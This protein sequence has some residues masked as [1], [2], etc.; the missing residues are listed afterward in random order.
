MLGCVSQHA[1]A[2]PHQHLAQAEAKELEAMT[3]DA[4][5]DGEMQRMIHDEQQQLA[6]QVTLSA[7]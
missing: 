5:Q 7:V 3:G 4:G 1:H 2:W 6:V